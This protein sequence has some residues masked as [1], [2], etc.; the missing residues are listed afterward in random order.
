M[1]IVAAIPVH[2]RHPLLKYTIKR[3][4]M[5][6]GVSEV[7]CVGGKADRSTCEEYGANFIHSTNYPL[8]GKWNRAFMATKDLDPDAVLFVGSSDWVS[9]KWCETM[10]PYLETSYMVGKLGCHLLDIGYIYRLCY[11]PGYRHGSRRFDP[12][13]H[14][15]P[16]GI[17][18]LLSRDFLKKIQYKPFDNHMD[19]SLDWQMYQKANGKVNISTDDVHSM[20]I[21]THQ[22]DNKHKFNDHWNGILKSKPMTLDFCDNN[23]PEYKLIFNDRV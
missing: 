13:R 5:K 12:R 7:V 10:F 15:E 18:R 19:N 11:W 3:L 9:D 4:L 2:G 8:G 23:F 1:K 16:I 21:S 22:W 17:G 14:D 20:S 6:C